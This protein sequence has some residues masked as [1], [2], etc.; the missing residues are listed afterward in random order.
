MVTAERVARI[1]E[2]TGGPV[3]LIA[4]GADV[5]ERQLDELT[6]YFGARRTPVVLVQVRRRATRDQQQGERTFYLDSQ[7]SSRETP[8]FVGALS[9]Y[10]PNR[11]AAIESLGEA[12]NQGLHRPVYFALTAYEQAFTALKDFVSPRIAGLSDDQTE[13]LVYTAIALHYGQ[14]GLP[15]NALRPIFGLSARDRT[16][17][18]L[19]FPAATEE[20]FVETSPG[21]WRIGHS[22]V[23]GELLEQLLAAGGDRR[24]WRNRL[25]DWGIR[26]ITFC[27]GDIPVASAEMLDLVQRIFVD[28]EGLDVLGREQSRQQQFS[29]FIQQVPVSE[30]R[31]RV[32]NALVESYPDEHHFWAHLARFHG[33]ER[34][35]FAEALV[36]ADYAVGLSDHDPVVYH[37]RGQVRRNQVRELIRQPDADVTELVSIAERP[38]PTSSSREPSTRRTNTATSLKRRCASRSLSMST[39]LTAISSTSSLDMMPLPISERHWT[40]LRACWRM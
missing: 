6:E 13:A 28:R 11:T 29:H 18:P 34:K 4:D 31:L 39:R 14:R 25:A 30:G 23:A 33:N 16:D 22:L 15:A 21:E 12:K 9:R 8:R 10:V 19:L 35:D 2:L 26:F 24:T 5:A 37:M 1:H 20:L 3:L 36:A 38:P 27:R 32:L 17:V 40:A 7:L